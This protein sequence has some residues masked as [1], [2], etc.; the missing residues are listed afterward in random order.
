MC[1]CM[2]IYMWGKA[3][4]KNTSCNVIDNFRHFAKTLVEYSDVQWST[5]RNIPWLK[6]KWL[7]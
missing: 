1:I 6:E 3:L 5:P 4:S 7:N 2:Y